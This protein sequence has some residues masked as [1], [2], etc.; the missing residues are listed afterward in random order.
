VPK[1][2]RN[3]VF[4][5]AISEVLKF[6]PAI[7]TEAEAIV[8]DIG[9]QT[10]TET[11]SLDATFPYLS[12]KG[13]GGGTAYMSLCGL[14]VLSL[15]GLKRPSAN[16]MY[17][18]VDK[19]PGG[20]LT[21]KEVEVV[22]YVKGGGEKKYLQ[23]QL[24]SWTVST[25][26][27]GVPWEHTFEAEEAPETVDSSFGFS[28]DVDYMYEKGAW[29]QFSSLDVYSN[30]Y[31]STIVDGLGVPGYQAHS[32]PLAAAAVIILCGAAHYGVEEIGG[33]VVDMLR[34]VEKHG[35]RSHRLPASL[36]WMVKLHH[37]GRKDLKFRRAAP[38]IF[39]MIEKSL[40][41]ARSDVER[42]E[43]GAVEAADLQKSFDILVRRSAS[44]DGWGH[45]LFLGAENMAFYLLSAAQA[46]PRTPP[47]DPWG[48]KMLGLYRTMA[49]EL[50]GGGARV[51]MDM[52]KALPVLW[53]YHAC[54]DVPRRVFE[55]ITT[56]AGVF[57]AKSRWIRS[58]DL[59]AIGS[60]ADTLECDWRSIHT[61]IREVHGGKTFALAVAM[62]E[63][64]FEWSKSLPLDGD[65][66]FE[67]AAR[68]AELAS[69]LLR[70]GIAGFLHSETVLAL[71]KAKTPLA[72]IEKLGREN[73]EGKVLTDIL[74]QVYDKVE[75]KTHDLGDLISLH[76]F[77]SAGVGYST[78]MEASGP[79]E[80]ERTPRQNVD[81][82]DEEVWVEPWGVSSNKKSLTML[83][84]AHPPEE[85]LKRLDT[86]LPLDRRSG[87]RS[88]PTTCAA[89]SDRRR[90][91]S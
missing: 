29:S 82:R 23:H 64:L 61:A 69:P 75:P 80:R 87:E 84:T 50:A 89:G 9:K 83:Y 2:K 49:I 8:E 39:S 70:Q 65:A 56:D 4:R 15:L 18:V 60:L 26:I 31:L 3:A 24:A 22:E 30:A 66:P 7:L 86:T 72:R 14:D 35:T 47:T 36:R 52:R 13:H 71:G 25:T 53:T 16:E 27:D 77:T 54:F 63:E 44:L 81:A 78:K 62:Y 32:Q 74:N 10:G 79:A 88:W 21:T 17:Y 46:R 19:N 40:D 67:W 11:L 73:M 59:V 55:R 42:F 45:A 90:G 33:S 1:A 68:R 41:K 76:K 28:S 37:A 91:H 58:K 85:I 51:G 57:E 34:H 38:S 48:M 43:G 12:T 20:T 5:A 6:D